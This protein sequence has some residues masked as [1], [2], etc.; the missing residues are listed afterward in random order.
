MR[1]VDIVYLYEHAARELDVACAITARLQEAGVQVEIV[2]WPTGFPHVVTRIRPRLVVLPF[3][4]T[5]DSY[6]ALLAYWREAV[7]FNLSWE[8]LFYSGNRQAKTPRGEFAL[9]H[10]VHHAWSEMYKSFLMKNSLAEK[11]IFLNGQPAYALY[12]KPYR[13]Y[14]P[15]RAELALQHGFDPTR[16]WVF[17][18]ENYNWAFYSEATIQQ[19]VR[20]GQSLA[21]IGEMRDYCNRSLKDVLQWLA[22]AAR[23]EQVE[24]ILRP[25]P[26]ATM[27]EFQAF[28]GN[29]L[30]ETPPHLHIL[31]QGSIREWILASDV[32]LSSHSTSLIEGAVAGKSVFIVEPHPMPTALKVEWHDLLGHLKSCDE[33]N[34]VCAGKSINEDA[35]LKEWARETMMRSGDPIDNLAGFILQSLSGGVEMPSP[36]PRQIATP[37]L[38]WIPPAWLWSMYRR[39]KQQLRFRGTGGIEPEFVKDVFSREG[40]ND[41]VQKWSRLMAT[42]G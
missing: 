20:G 21:E 17:F 8:Q 16:R 39:V 38:K 4:Y 25:R 31:Q 15:S 29:I 19:F 10:V 7:F 6:D 35:R 34:Q 36:P 37:A 42:S 22:H 2:H 41:R 3:C 14:F 32:I 5:E 26:S 9:K 13:G 23:N 33:V 11:N 27:K 28:V 12:D 30:P 40:I 1:D 18:P 24:I